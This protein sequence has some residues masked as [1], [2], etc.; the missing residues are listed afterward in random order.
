MKIKIKDY[1]QFKYQPEKHNYFVK[2]V[3]NFKLKIKLT[4][5]FL[6]IEIKKC[7]VSLYSKVI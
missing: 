4:F 2:K 7:L 1:F 5:Y 3:C 6:T